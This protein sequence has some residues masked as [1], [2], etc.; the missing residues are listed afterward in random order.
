M[1]PEHDRARA[2]AADV[3][4]P[5]TIYSGTINHA[6][7]D[8]APWPITRRLSTPITTPVTIIGGHTPAP[9][10]AWIDDANCYG[11]TDLM[12][13]ESRAARVAAIAICNGCPVIEPCA[14]YG[15]KEVYGVWAG[16]LMNPKGGPRTPM[17]HG[18][19]PGY[20]KHKDYPHLY[21]PPCEPCRDANYIASV[22]R[23]DRNRMKN[24]QQRRRHRQEQRRT[25]EGA[26]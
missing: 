10:L 8:P 15:A 7:L 4:H 6:R 1:T 11:R 13:A 14:E 12:F 18:T 16:V 24:E 25:Q 5:N 19:E 9:D 3:A 26:A 22:G 21:G 20:R 17:V 2:A 23:K